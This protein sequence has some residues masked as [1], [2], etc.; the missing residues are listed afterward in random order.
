MFRFWERTEGTF[1][2]R[3]IKSA[4]F[5]TGKNLIL[6]GKLWREYAEVS[7]LWEDQTTQAEEY[8]DTDEQIY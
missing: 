8:K 5:F 7:S 1:F 3:Y 6:R 2:D 4:S